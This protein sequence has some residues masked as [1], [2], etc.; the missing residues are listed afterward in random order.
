MSNLAVAHEFLIFGRGS[1]ASPDGGRAL[2]DMGEE[3]VLAVGQYLEKNIF[4]GAVKVM[5]SG[6]WAAGEGLSRP[7]DEFLE[8]NMMRDFDLEFHAIP[9]T[10]DGPGDV[11]QVVHKAVQPFSYS[12]ISDAVYAARSGFFGDRPF[13]FTAEHPIGV[14]AQAREGAN[15]EDIDQGG[16]M[17]RCIDA[18]MSA[19]RIPRNAIVPVIAAGEDTPGSG[20]SEETVTKITRKVTAPFSSYAGLLI[21]DNM[22]IKASVAIQRIAHLHG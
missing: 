12:T 19:L 3:R 16:H 22:M 14:V 18:T 9:T 8:A 1:V 7:A 20:I 17:A 10:V 21:V 13:P 15:P 2:S 4:M 11:K 5:F 6:G